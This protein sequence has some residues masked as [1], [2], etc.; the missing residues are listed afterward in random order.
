MRRSFAAT[1]ALAAAFVF[2]T[3]AMAQQASFSESDQ[4]DED[5]TT[6]MRFLERAEMSGTATSIGVD[7]QEL[8]R[9]TQGMSD[10][11]A[12]RVAQQVRDAEQAMAADSIT[13]TTTAIIIGLLILIAL[14]LIL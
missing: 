11:D 5:R 9:R 14:I 6:I 2:T 8:G 4:G 13:I 7:A 1:L 12:A 10:A 3:P